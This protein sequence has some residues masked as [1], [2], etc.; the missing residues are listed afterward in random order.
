MERTSAFIEAS[1]SAGSFFVHSSISAM[2]FDGMRNRFTNGL[3]RSISD[4]D[5]SPTFTPS[6]S[7]SSL[8]KLP[9]RMKFFPPNTRLSG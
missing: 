9:P 4:A 8:A 2:R 5:K 3:M 7:S 1:T 6:G